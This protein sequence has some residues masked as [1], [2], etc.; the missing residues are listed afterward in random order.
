MGDFALQQGDQ[1]VVAV[2]ATNG[3]P[4][5]AG[6]VVASFADATEWTVTT[7]GV[8]EVTV[9][10]TGALVTGDLLTVTGTQNGAAITPGTL[11]FD[12]VGAPAITL[13]PG[14]PTPIAPAA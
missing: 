14:T 11:S 3:V 1:V 9:E 5:D 4:F 13:T 10:A 6:S 8:S 12:E 7:D 2:T